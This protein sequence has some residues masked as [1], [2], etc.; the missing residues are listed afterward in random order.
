MIEIK[1]YEDKYQDEVINL[2]LSCQND[3]SR[4]IVSIA[5]Q[6]ELLNINKEYFS[7]GGYFWIAIESKKLVGTI[8]LINCENG[9]GI[10]KK[11]FVNEQY[12]GKPYNLGRK[13]FAELLNFAHEHKFK[14]LVLD[15]P[16]NTERAHKFYEKAGFKKVSQEDLPI[17][18]NPPYKD[19]DFFQLKLF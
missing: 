6:P 11:F 1:K 17:K 18:Y 15:T 2:V 3:G 7:N 19:S 14:E 5:N 12:R 13:L 8:G 4:P 9:I 16:K 10:L